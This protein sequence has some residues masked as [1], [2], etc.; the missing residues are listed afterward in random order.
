MKWFFVRFFFVCMYVWNLYKFTFL[1]RSEPNFAH[2][3]PLVWKRPYDMYWPEIL[4]L[5]DLSVPFSLGATAESWAQDGCRRDRLPW[6][7]YIYDS[8]W[9][10][11]MARYIREFRSVFLRR[12]TRGAL[13]PRNALQRQRFVRYS[14]TCS[15]DVTHTTPWRAPIAH[16]YCASL[17][18][19]V[20]LRKRREDNGMH[21][22]KRGNLMTLGGGVNNDWLL[23]SQ[24]YT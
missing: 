22:C 6:Y 10:C 4:D 18:L 20:M 2:V 1:N 15:C 21:A 9:C 19:C 3:S 11:V 13:H 16:S 12:H 8:S 14:D 7:L 5:F 24:L 17:A 23:H